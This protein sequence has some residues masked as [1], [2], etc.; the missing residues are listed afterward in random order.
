MN[1]WPFKKTFRKDIRLGLILMLDKASKKI[2]SNINMQ[3][4]SAD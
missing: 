4:N 3:G 1:D 2:N